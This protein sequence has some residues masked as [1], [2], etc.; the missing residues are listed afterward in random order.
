MWTD[1]AAGS[2]LLCAALLPL[3]YYAA[4]LLLPPFL[5]PSHWA[6]A[7][8]PERKWAVAVPAAGFS[9]ILAVVT[10]FVGFVLIREEVC[11]DDPEVET[12]DQEVEDTDKR[13]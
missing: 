8:F 3:A 2:A 4:W 9:L 1:R 7:A 13:G 6:A 10:S 5:A 11:E 12:D